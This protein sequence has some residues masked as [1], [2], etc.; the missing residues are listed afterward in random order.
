MAQKV[1][2]KTVKREDLG[3]M[4]SPPTAE[5]IRSLKKTWLSESPS[6][7]SLHMYTYVYKVT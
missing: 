4:M 5:I 6:S 1:F 7:P 2:L 3:T